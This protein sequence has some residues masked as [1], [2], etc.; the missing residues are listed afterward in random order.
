MGVIIDNQLIFKSHICNIL[1]K[2]SQKFNTLT[3]IASSKD[4]KKKENNHE[5]LY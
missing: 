3:R 5:S 2:A 4:Q 1:K